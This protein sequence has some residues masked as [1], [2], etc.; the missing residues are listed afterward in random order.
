MSTAAPG[1]EKAVDRQLISFVQANIGE[2]LR[3]SRHYLE[4][5]ADAETLAELMDEAWAA[6]A[7]RPLSALVEV[8][9]D[10]D[11]EAIGLA[12]GPLA[13]SL[14]RSGLVGSLA[15]GVVREVLQAYG[16]HQVAALLT[17]WGVEQG[18]VV[19]AVVAIVGPALE[20]A[21]A[22]GYL[23]GRL[24]ARLE[25]FYASLGER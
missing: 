6:V 5:H 23:A 4:E 18:A 14:L 11:L 16:R 2:T 8:V 1:L 17:D 21:H 15:A 3:E 9:T 10:Q 12:A 13:E 24:R 7:T 19:D 25:P 22:S 20:H